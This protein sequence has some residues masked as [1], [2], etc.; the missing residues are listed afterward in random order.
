MPSPWNNGLPGARGYLKVGTW[1]GA[2]KR[3]NNIEQ[4]LP[5]HSDVTARWTIRFLAPPAGAAGGRRPRGRWRWTGKGSIALTPGGI[6]LQGRRQRSFWLP[7]QQRIELT[8]AQIRNVAVDGS[9]VRFEAVVN[10]GKPEVVRLRAADVQAAKALAAALP[11]ACT[12]EFSRAQTEQQAFTQALQ[13][14]GTRP[15]VT[16]SLVAVNVLVYIA[17]ASHGAGWVTAQPAVLI[18]WGTNYEPATLAGEW[19]RLFTSMFLHFGLLHI[20]LNMWVLV[21]LGPR[22]E[23]LFGSAC[24]LLLYLFAGL[25][26]SVASVWWHTAV[27]SAGASGAIFGVIG[28]LLAFTLN[29]ATRLPASITANQRTSAAVFVFYNLLYGFGH[30]GIDNACH[31]GGLLGGL[32]MGWLLAQPLDPVA[33]REQP[34]RLAVATALGAA[35][36]LALVWALSRRPHLSQAEIAFRV[37]VQSISADETRAQDRARELEQTLRQRKITDAQWGA[38][39]AG[40]VV[41]IWAA[42]EDRIRNDPLPANSSL[43]TLRQALLDYIDQRRQ[44]LE[45]F[46]KAAILDNAWDLQM[47]QEMMAR[48]NDAAK[49]ASR[50]ITAIE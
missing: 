35:T 37:D 4:A 50:L 45:L 16:W 43:T 34:R 7:V 46:S 2:T 39:I 19:W 8:V 41:P 28:G 30:Q 3:M 21:S 27:N 1:A 26:G 14:L 17:A 11:T 32:A 18:H 10:E 25:C 33:R 24:Y 29:P 42:M 31:V 38:Q 13:Q 49:R 5:A 20:A 36:L 15:L 23:R 22:V 47:G 44:A 48:S 6:E 40:T 12:P 9:V